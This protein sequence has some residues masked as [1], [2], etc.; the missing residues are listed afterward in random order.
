VNALAHFRDEAEHIGA[1]RVARIHEKIGVPVADA[2]VS[3]GKAFEP[4]FVNHPSGGPAG[5]IFEN[6]ARAFLVE[7]LAGTSFFVA[8]AN[9]F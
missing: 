6:T 8:D 1:A 7:R 3:N 9:A 4:Q 2:G 5:R